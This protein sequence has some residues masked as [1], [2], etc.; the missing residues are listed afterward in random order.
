MKQSAL[1]L[2]VTI[3]SVALVALV[4]LVA[5]K[6]S[7]KVCSSTDYGWK[8]QIFSEQKKE[9][10]SQQQRCE[11]R[12]GLWVTLHPYVY[13]QGREKPWYGCRI[14]VADAG[15]I[16]GDANQCQSG[17]CL[18]ESSEAIAYAKRHN[19]VRMD[20]NILD[21]YQLPNITCS[22]TESCQG[23]CDTYK[24]VNDP[25]APGSDCGIN[26]WPS[27]YQL[28]DG[29]LIGKCWSGAGE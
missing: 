20:V 22:A 3:A 12:N 9:L 7:A 11:S 2:G 16:C 4:A 27:Y 13:E 17:R 8:C 14:P 18:V 1:L 23:K 15:K 26:P 6:S 5:V 28:Q 29:M 24:L 21:R 10:L 25:N 19:Q